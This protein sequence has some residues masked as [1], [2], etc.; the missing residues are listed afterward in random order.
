LPLPTLGNT[1]KASDG[2]DA[3]S[4]FAM[5]PRQKPSYVVGKP[6]DTT[7]FAERSIS[8]K[9]TFAI[10]LVDKQLIMNRL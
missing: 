1:L 9:L 3:C 2:S 10:G 4:H 7:L 5:T 8:A 6:D